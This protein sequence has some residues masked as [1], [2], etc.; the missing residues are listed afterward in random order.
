M[1]GEALRMG[2]AKAMTSS[3]STATVR[4]STAD[5]PQQHRIAMWREHY[6]HKVLRVDVEPLGDASFAASLTSRA[7]PGLQLL[8]GTMSVTRIARTRSL[9]ADGNNDFALIINRGGA[10]AASAHNREVFLL[11]GDAVLMSFSDVT[12]FE[13]YAPGGSFA[14]RI[15]RVV[16]SRLVADVDDAVMRLIPRHVEALKLLSG[17]ARLLLDEPSVTAGGLLRL[18]VAHVHD[19]VALALGTS[20]GAP[21]TT[22]PRGTR[23]GRLGLAKAYVIENC[24]RRDLSIGAVAAHLG[25]TERYVQRLFEGDAVTF[26]SFLLGERLTRAYRM[27]TDLKYADRTVSAIAYDIGFNDISYFNRCF[28]RR[29]GA[30]PRDIREHRRHA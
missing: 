22:R 10:L 8:L 25:V 21:E 7:L 13:R 5:L 20:P 12:T 18:S 16:L 24:N 27:L 19:L 2:I 23:V 17:Y 3:G 29:Y 1:E 28:R 26:S 4:F 15:P 14:L 30:T 11:E 6:A 9:I